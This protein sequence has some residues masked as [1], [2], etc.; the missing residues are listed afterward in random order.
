MSEAV[1][2]SLGGTVCEGCPFHLVL[3]HPLGKSAVM[4]MS[5][6]GVLDVGQNI[7]VSDIISRR[8][9]MS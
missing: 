4:A 2:A 8:S 3:P 9:D 5:E 6:E 1:G 7:G